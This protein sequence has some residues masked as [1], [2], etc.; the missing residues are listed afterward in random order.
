[1]SLKALKRPKKLLNKQRLDNFY[2]NLVE[3]FLQEDVSKQNEVILTEVKEKIRIIK[4]TTGT[5]AEKVII[6]LFKLE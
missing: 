3:S 2:I 4:E 5:A 1:M 6:I